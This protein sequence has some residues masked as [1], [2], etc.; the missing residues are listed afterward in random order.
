MCLIVFG[1]LYLSQLG[2]FRAT[3][4]S[5][6]KSLVRRVSMTISPKFMHNIFLK[7]VLTNDTAD[8]AD[9][10]FLKPVDFISGDEPAEIM[11]K[12]IGG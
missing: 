6:G 2:H 1:Q 7:D 12:Q 5:T 9:G 10:T 8:T 11:W 3:V 4:G